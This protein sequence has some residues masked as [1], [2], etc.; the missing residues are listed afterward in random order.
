MLLKDLSYYKTSGTCEQLIEPQSIKELTS[1]MRHIDHE[2][3]KYFLLGAGSNSFIMDKHWPEVVIC[4]R[5]LNRI[6]VKQTRVIVETGVDNSEL[7]QVC[8]DASLAV[9]N[10]LNSLICCAIPRD[11][12]TV[13][14]PL[15]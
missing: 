5:K 13:Q 9:V 6:I 15:R 8:C 12:Q 4:F 2:M 1:T 11:K 3:I 14:G 10:W 7:A